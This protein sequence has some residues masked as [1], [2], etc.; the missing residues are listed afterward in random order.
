VSWNRGGGDGDAPSADG[1]LTAV[2]PENRIAVTLFCA[3]STQWERAG[4][5]GAATGLKYEAIPATAGMMG[6]RLTPV[7]FDDL[8][9]MEAAAL[10]V[11]AA[12]QKT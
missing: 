4:M 7:L 9:T 10:E 11:M 2:W 3:L 1:G 12:R 5:T 6:I 8:R